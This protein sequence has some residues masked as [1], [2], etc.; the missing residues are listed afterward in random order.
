MI[1]FTGIEFVSDRFVTSKIIRRLLTALYADKD[2]SYFI[3]NSG[4]TVFSCNEMG[5]LNTGL[6]NINLD[7]TNYDKDDPEAIIHITFLAWH[8]K[9][10]KRKKKIS[11]ET[12]PMAWHPKRWWNFCMYEADKKKTQFLLSNDFSVYTIWVYWNNLPLDIVQKS[13]WISSHFDS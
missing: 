11:E 2:V 3:K 9:F 12:M 1:F 4:D 5:I 8:I 6:N 10:K 7:D 13:L